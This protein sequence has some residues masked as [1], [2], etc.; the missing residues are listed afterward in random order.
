MKDIALPYYHEFSVFYCSIEIK[1]II[2]RFLGKQQLLL[3]RV[4]LTQQQ[5]PCGYGCSG[6][7]NGVVVYGGF[8]KYHLFSRSFF[9][10]PAPPHF[11]LTLP[12]CLLSNA[13]RTSSV[14]TVVIGVV[15]ILDHS[16]VLELWV[17]LF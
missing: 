17:F 15:I 6:S 13:I 4:Q 11:I 10:P 7:C 8:F 16:S 12:D 14:A 1:A 3:H 2:S 9:L 5:C